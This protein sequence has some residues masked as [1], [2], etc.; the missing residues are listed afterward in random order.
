MIES[1]FSAGKNVE[2]R[3]E[4]EQLGEV[5]VPALAIMDDEDQNLVVKYKSLRGEEDEWRKISVPYSKIRPS[6]SP[7]GLRS[8]KLMEKVEALNESGWCR[9]VVCKTLSGNRY[10]VLLGENKQSSDFNYSK[11]R[12]LV[13]WKDGAWQTEEKVVCYFSVSVGFFGKML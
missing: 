9:G 10:T 1:E 4:V 11:L 6:P 2:V 3:M 13:E 8:Y 5:W 12:P 7:V